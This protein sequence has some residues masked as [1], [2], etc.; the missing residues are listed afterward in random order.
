LGSREEV[1]VV[2]EPVAAGQVVTSADLR[3]AR[4]STGSGLDV[5]LSGIGSA[6]PKPGW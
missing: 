1:L 3:A 2:T 6:S 5:V 4:V